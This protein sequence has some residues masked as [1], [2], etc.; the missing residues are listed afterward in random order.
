MPIV[1]PP[2]CPNDRGRDD[3]REKKIW[4]PQKPLDFD[5]L[6]ETLRTKSGKSWPEIIKEY[7]KTKQKTEQKKNK[8]SKRKNRKSKKKR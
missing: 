5:V 6:G 7:W 1:F 3:L 2:F 8:K 4:I